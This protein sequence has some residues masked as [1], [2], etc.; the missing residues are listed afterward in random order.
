MQEYNLS[1][2][3][4]EDNK[5]GHLEGRLQ[6]SANGTILRGPIEDKDSPEPHRHASA[7]IQQT[8]DE[9]KLEIM[10]LKSIHYHIVKMGMFYLILI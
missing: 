3:Y 2:L 5:R 9:I 7:R 6:V 4:Q 1:G 8:K 10:V